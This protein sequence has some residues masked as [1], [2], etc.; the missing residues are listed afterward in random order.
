M[1][2]QTFHPPFSLPYSIFLGNWGLERSWIR[3]Y[4]VDCQFSVA[5]FLESSPQRAA[6]LHPPASR[7][8]PSHNVLPHRILCPMAR[9]RTHPK[10]RQLGHALVAPGPNPELQ[11]HLLPLCL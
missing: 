6:S 3:Y 11:L 7:A 9:P 5:P 1:T 2:P 4:L 8:P 10:D